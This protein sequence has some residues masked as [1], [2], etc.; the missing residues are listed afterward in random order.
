[1]LLRGSQMMNNHFLKDNIPKCH[2][3]L[4][5]EIGN[6][7]GLRILRRSFLNLSPCQSIS[8][9]NDGAAL[10]VETQISTTHTQER[11]VH[12]RKCTSATKMLIKS[13]K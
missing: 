6:W 5:C 11:P 2:T 8:Q 1:M 7:A 9:T 12:Y 10:G 3:C 13:A 4:R